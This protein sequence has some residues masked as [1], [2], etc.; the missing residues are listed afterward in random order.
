MNIRS[1]NAIYTIVLLLAMFVVW[2]VRQNNHVNLVSFSGR[3]MGPIIYRVQYFDKENRNFQSEIDSVLRAFNLSLNTYN[4]DSEISIFNRDSSFVFSLPYFHPV[5]ASSRKIYDLS[6]GAYDPTIMP[7]VKTWGFGPGK[8]VNMDSSLIDSLTQLVDFEK[9]SFDENSVIKKDSRVMLDFSASAKGYGVDVVADF[10]KDKGIE[11]SFIEI[12]GEV[13]AKGIN[14][15]SGKPWTV[16]I[17]NP[18]SDE[19]NQF[20]IAIASLENRAMATSGNYFNYYI[21]DS[22][23]Y[24]HTIS[25]YTGYPIIHSLL[26]ASVFADNCLEADALATA[27]MVLGYEKSIEILDQHPEYDAFL[28]L[29]DKQGNLSTY[30]T[31]GVGSSITDVQK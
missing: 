21:I 19:I 27:F 3:T 16:G 6:S 13:V 24:A 28:V 29:S 25:P 20:P 1:K 12:G 17:L 5:L 9:I 14:L 10:L 11:N 15:S 22:V 30:A 23:K 26:S 4:P 7:L 31:E 2:K 8:E 18:N